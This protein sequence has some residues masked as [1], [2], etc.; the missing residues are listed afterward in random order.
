VNKLSDIQVDV[1]RVLRHVTIAGLSPE[2]RRLILNLNFP[3]SEGIDS[4]DPDVANAAAQRVARHYLGIRPA[5]PATKVARLSDGSHPPRRKPVV[6]ASASAKA[7]APR[8]S[9][10]RD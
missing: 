2:E 6:K 1:K 7:K 9:S 4:E 3:G 10:K 5:A 8:K